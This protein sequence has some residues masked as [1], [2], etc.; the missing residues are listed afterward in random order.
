MYGPSVCQQHKVI[1]LLERLIHYINNNN[2]E[3]NIN[4][5]AHN[6]G[7][8]HVCTSLKNQGSKTTNAADH[9]MVSECDSFFIFFISTE[10][11][12]CVKL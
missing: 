12:L 1:E 5:C 6:S 10:M 11:S 7:P 3:S 9:Y 2:M 4:D 8:K